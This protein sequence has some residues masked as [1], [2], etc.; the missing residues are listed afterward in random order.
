MAEENFAKDSQGAARQSLSRRKFMLLTGTVASGLL[1]AACAAPVPAAQPATSAGGTPAIAPATVS[2]WV[3]SAL[4]LDRETLTSVPADKTENVVGYIDWNLEKFNEVEPETE[5][6]LEYLPHDQSWFAKLDSALIAGTP[7]DVVQGP[8]SE[9]AKYIPLGALSSVNDYIAKEILDD[10]HPAIVAEASFDGKQYLWP[11]RLSFGGGISLNGGMWAQN[12]VAD[13]LPT[14]ETRRWEMD[15]FLEAAKANTTEGAYGVVLC[16]DIH[17][18]T[19]QFMYGFGARLFNEDETEIALNSPEGVEGLQW[20]LDLEHV[21]KVAVPGTAIRKSAEAGQLFTE[22]KAGAFGAQGS[23]KTPP[24]FAERPEFNWYW[25]PP[26]N[27]PGK[28]PAVM[29]NIHGHYVFQQK[30]AAQ[31]EAAH[32]WTQFLVRPESL[33]LSL[34]AFGMPPALQSLWGQVEDENMKVGLTFTS[35]MSTLGR[36]ASAAAITFSLAP[37]M[38]EAAFSGQMTAQEALDQF[39][40]EG[41]ELIQEA[42]NA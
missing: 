22:G 36:R 2:H 5:V 10:L 12:G 37:R 41:N 18:Q 28:E 40:L 39:A 19:T 21:H 13:L 38:L 30:N 31:T 8:I 32:R 20:L 4:P 14:G 6:Q 16:T 29:T 26:P 42:L 7:P 3:Y 9:A 17:Y 24:E 27:V 15:T 34:K 11:W 1:V 25:A 35:M 23:G 33:E